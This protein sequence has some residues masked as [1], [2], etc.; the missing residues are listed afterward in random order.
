MLVTNHLAASA[1]FDVVRINAEFAD[2]TS[3]HDPLVAAFDLPPPTT[4]YTLQLLHL[5]DGEAGLLAPQT[6]PNLAA[7]VDA[8]D[9]D[10]ANTLILAGGDDFLAGPFLAGGTDLSVTATLNAV[11]GSTIGATTNIPIGAVDIAMLNA[12][13]VEASTIGNHEFDLGSRVL[14]DAFSPNLGA[15]GWVGA[16]FPYLS[17]NLDFS[18]DADL[19]P[20]FT[21]TLDGGT[22]TLI[23][24]ASTLKGRIAPSAVITKGGEKIGLVAATTQILEAI[25]SPTGT[26]VKGF[27]TGPGA[28]GEV[29]DMNLLAAQLQPVINELIAEGVNKIIL[30]S[31]LQ[32]IENEQLLATKLTG[33]DIILSAGSNTRLADADDDLVA[34][35]GHEA[36]ADGPYPIVTQGLDGKPTLIVNTDGE[37]TYLGRLVVE[38]DANGEII[39]D[40]LTANQAING[41]HAATADNVAEAWGTTV[42]NLAD[43]AFADGTKGDKVEDLTDAVQAVINIQDGNVFGFTDVYLEGERAI[44]RTQET[45]LGDLSADANSF[46]ARE[47][48]GDTPL[49][50]SLKN[51]GGI[52]AQI[53]TV[54]DPD[55]VTGEID[56]LPPA[57]NPEAGKPEGGVSQLDIENSL[58]FN[59][60][61][62]VFDTT[63][64]G[65]LNILNWGAGLPANNGG[66]PQIGGVRFSYDPDL[67]GNVGS[68]P[69]SRIRDVALIDENGNVVALIVDDGVVVPGAPALISV[70]TLNFTANGGDGYP[71]KA[72]GE[73]FRYLLNDGTLSAPVSEVLDFTAPANAPANALGE[74]KAFAD[75]MQ[76]FHATPGTAYDQADTPISEDTR[77]QNLNFRDDT[78]FDSAPIFG[79][80]NDNV[81]NGTA[82]NDTIDGRDGDD[83]IFGKGGADDLKGGRGDDKISGGDGNDL[84]DGARGDDTMDGG[85]GN[86]IFVADLPSDDDHGH[87]HHDRPWWWFDDWHDGLSRWFGG[88]RHDEGDTYDGGAGVDTLDF[89]AVS[90][91]VEI[92]LNDGTTRFGSDTIKNIENLWGGSNGDELAGNDLAN[93]LRG[94]GGDDELDG[95]K[96]NDRLFGG[97]GKVDL[98]GGKGNDVLVGGKGKDTL[99]GGDGID[100]FVFNSLDDARDVIRDFDKHG[101]DKDQIV[102]AQTMF[103]GFAGDDG[104]DLVA[105]GF[106]RTRSI[107]GGKTEIQVDVDGGGNSWQALA[108]VSTQ[109]TSAELATQVVLVQDPVV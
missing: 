107:G 11:S 68:T 51:G 40:S 73:N 21:N 108:E 4:N 80:N 91:E 14:R 78:V 71:V 28:N 100:Q 109:L 2:Q 34:F 77:I 86:D 58:R 102:L 65:L 103:T 70:V 54:S 69:G 90:D 101:S 15:A 23:P 50:V 3:D 61:L 98:G 32:Q 84:I 25:S 66:F 33:V 76:E 95:E 5:S 19:N 106:L 89:R 18:G 24:E 96:G 56:K 48:I 9:D 44:V 57:A 72:N 75:Y 85:T 92:D 67:P 83:K 88:D 35:P 37:Y 104:A 43:T 46:A 60:R 41:A 20:R 94:N 63:P 31:H 7:L 47:A 22:G 16:Q 79:D 27:P 53:G 6:A 97:E 82:G 105:G 81:L 42:G 49:L 36:T 93:V 12:I 52:R 8:F 99:T 39:L 74:Q 45:N 64:Q 30:Q 55:P 29:D 13:G 1:Q 87:G 26:E 38:F 62:M 17:A 10:Y 59:N